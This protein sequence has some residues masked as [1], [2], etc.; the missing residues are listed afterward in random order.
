MGDL[1]SL[2]P[3]A[4]V[5]AGVFSTLGYILSTL[6]HQKRILSLSQQLAISQTNEKNLEKQ[7][8]QQKKF[9]EGVTEVTKAQFENLAHQILDAKSKSLHETSE[10]N[11]SHIL[12]PL[13]ERIETFEKQVA[14]TYSNEAKERFALK[15]EVEKL[16]DL[17]QKITEEANHLALALKGNPKIQGDWGEM[18][19]ERILESSGL[20][21]GIEYVAQKEYRGPE[22]EL[23]RPDVVIYLPESKHLVIDAKVSLKAYEQYARSH[24]EQKLAC[25]KDHLHS[26]N[27]HI[28]RLSEKHY[29]K[30]QGIRAPEFVFM[31]LPVEPAYFLILEHDPDIIPRAWKKGIALTTATTLFTTLK[32]VSSIWR[33]ENQNRNALE[34]A[35]EGGRLYDKFVNFLEDFEKMEAVFLSGQKLY[36]SA[37]G[38]LKLG[39]GNIFR[40]MERL[41]ELGASTSKQ[42]KEEYLT[43]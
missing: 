22:G 21:S 4:L 2:L 25:L 31:F 18:I 5:S 28:D 30:A 39:P 38:K 29:E 9:V 42:V 35:T 16:M 34:I 7:I 3:T 17:N 14:E 8:E 27:T 37:M 32:T 36:H 1:N 20:R 11:L 13:K 10:R 40:K 15:R 33:L 41:R 43:P 26:I 19:L 23:L 6:G 24:P 12:T